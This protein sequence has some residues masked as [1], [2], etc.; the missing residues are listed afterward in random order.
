MNMKKFINAKGVMLTELVAA[1]PLYLLLFMVL[2]FSLV[3]FISVYYETRMYIQLQEDVQF[4]LE[5][6]RFGF[7]KQ[8][9]NDKDVLIGLNTASS[10]N[11]HGQGNGITIKPRES[12]T[13]QYQATYRLDQSSGEIKLY[14]QYGSLAFNETVFPRFQGKIRRKLQFQVKEFEFTDK[15]PWMLPHTQPYL[16][17]VRIKA[18]VRLREKGRR[19]NATEDKKRNIREVEFETEVFLGNTVYN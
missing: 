19:Q 2:T 16:V 17:G 9:V 10:T 11:I 15:T 3:H 18:Q 14:A 1:I 5:S 12:G 4:A 6:I 13:V 8:F 7:A